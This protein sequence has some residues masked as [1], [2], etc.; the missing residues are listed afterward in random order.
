MAP[1]N[2]D[3]VGFD[4]EPGV[5]AFLERRLAGFVRRCSA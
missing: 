2:R 3:A 5:H 1:R 4:A